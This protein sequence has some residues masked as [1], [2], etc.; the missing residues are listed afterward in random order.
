VDDL[1]VLQGPVQAFQL[2]PE[3]GTVT[4]GNQLQGMIVPAGRRI[5]VRTMR[6]GGGSDG[7]LPAG[8]LTAIQ[9]FDASGNQINQTITVAAAHRHHRR[10]RPGDARR[11]PAAHSLAAPE[12]E[13]RRHR[14]RLQQPRAAD[15]GRNVARVEVLPLFKPQTHSIN[16]PGVVSVMVIPERTGS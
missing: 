10:R 4:F 14:G 1:A 11:R 7:N 16:V 12:S 8:S 5:R 3:A 13:P 2:D 9:A 6:A 15:S